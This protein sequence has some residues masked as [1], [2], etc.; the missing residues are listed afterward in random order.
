M[1]QTSSPGM[2][3]GVEGFV[4]SL[5]R[6]ILILVVRVGLEVGISMEEAQGVEEEEVVEAVE[7]AEEAAGTE[8]EEE[9]A[10]GAGAEEITGMR[11]E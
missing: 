6:I 11:K 5:K 2:C 3:D 9:E 1:P 10:G 4:K 7:E 8:E